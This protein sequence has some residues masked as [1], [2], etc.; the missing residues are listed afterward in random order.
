METLLA[1][2]NYPVVQFG[3]APFLA[4]L[5]V[6]V[7]LYRFHLGGLAMIAGLVT[8]FFLVVGFSF[9]PLTTLRKLFIVALATPLIGFSI[10]VTFRG[11]RFGAALA[12]LA[13]AAAAVWVFYPVLKQVGMPG[14]LLPG[15]VMGISIIWLVFVS[16][17]ALGERSVPCTVSA[18]AMALGVGVLATVGNAPSFAKFGFALGAGVGA[19]LLVLIISGRAYAAGATLALTAAVSCGLL[20]NAAMITAHLHWHAVAIFAL[21]PLAVRLPG[22]SRS[23]VWLQTIVYGLYAA[24]PMVVAYA[25]AVHGFAGGLRM[26][27]ELLNKL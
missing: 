9:T 16:L 4:G 19:F 5:V 2:L 1:Y 18:L 23:G 8:A 3:V 25:I 15:A 13:A 6:A 20:A 10:D 26:L 22:P 7:V 14:V 27:R 11:N 24:L 12:A 17:V 21:T